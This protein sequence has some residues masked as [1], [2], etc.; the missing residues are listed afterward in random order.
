MQRMTA[1]GGAPTGFVGREPELEVIFDATA[2]AA[3]GRSTT[4]L[5]E[6]SSGMGASRLIDEALQ[7]ISDLAARPGRLVSV[8]QADRLP[9]WRGAPYAPFRTALDRFLDGRRAA[10]ALGLLDPGAEI[11]LPLLRGPPAGWG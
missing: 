6:G 4:I 9:A 5:L 1:G 8:I 10:E 11:L 3:H 2:A 7:R